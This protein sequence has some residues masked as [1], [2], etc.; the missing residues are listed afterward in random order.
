MKQIG[1]N[2]RLAVQ[3]RRQ[4]HDALDSESEPT[5]IRCNLFFF[6]LPQQP[7]QAP[8][9]LVKA[10]GVRAWLFW[11]SASHDIARLAK[12]WGRG[13]SGKEDAARNGVL[14]PLRQ[15]VHR[16]LDSASR[17]I[18]DV[19]AVG[20][21]GRRTDDGRWSRQ[22]SRPVVSPFPDHHQGHLQPLVMTSMASPS[23]SLYLLSG[24]QSAP[25][26]RVLECRPLVTRHCFGLSISVPTASRT[27]SWASPRRH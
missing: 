26:E 16:Q 3:T 23:L 7:R 4:S 14:E 24:K 11:A 13:E 20:D 22:A 17:C 12:G 10:G 9:G 1:A 15:G 5:G 19:E 8:G 25:A 21:G 18:D 2:D 6:A 27:G